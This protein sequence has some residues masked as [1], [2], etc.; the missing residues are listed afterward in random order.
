[1][2]EVEGMAR[3][4]QVDTLHLIYWDGWVCKHETYTPSTMP[5]WKDTTRP[6][7][8]GGTYPSCI[9]PYLKEHNIK[10]DAAVI[11]TD[12]EVMGWGTWTIPTLWAI[13]GKN[14]APVGKT[15]HITE[16]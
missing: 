9:P 10:L 7:G 3:Q 4:L 15:I 13:T 14:T 1:M 8:G 12:G 16:D 6:S 11:L 5:S 2:S